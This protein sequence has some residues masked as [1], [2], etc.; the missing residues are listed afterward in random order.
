M[1]QLEHSMFE[2]LCIYLVIALG[3]VDS[4]LWKSKEFRR[5]VKF[6]GRGVIL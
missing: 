6:V 4:T 3:K 1:V 2:M 5:T